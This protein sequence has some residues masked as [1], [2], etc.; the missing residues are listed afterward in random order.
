MNESALKIAE[1][2]IGEC[3]SVA[4]QSGIN[5]TADGSHSF[6]FTGRILFRFYTNM[7]FKQ[8]CEMT[9]V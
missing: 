4:N 2:V 3:I 1:K 8:S 9:E 5:L 6:L 7:C